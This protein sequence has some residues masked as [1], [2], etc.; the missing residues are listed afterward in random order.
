MKQHDISAQISGERQQWAYFLK[1]NNE[2]N[3]NTK[4]RNYVNSEVGGT[5]ELLS[6]HSQTK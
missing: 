2:C 6:F 5:T 4:G 1:K 3:L